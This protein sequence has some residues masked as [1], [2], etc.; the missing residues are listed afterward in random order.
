[1]KQDFNA[2]GDL[3][4]YVS[5]P[6]GEY[7]CVVSEVREGVTRDGSPRWSFRLDVA[8]GEYAGR[9]AAWDGVGWGERGLPRTKHVLDALGFDVSGS[10]DVLPDD[11]NGCRVVANLVQEEREDPRTG[12][13]VARLHVPYLG[14]REA[15]P[16]ENAAPF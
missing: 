13:R 6:E 11:L 8:D 2:V 15:E 10:L 4:S 12:N 9:F 14:Y 3:E 7:V 5:V 16:A 1:V